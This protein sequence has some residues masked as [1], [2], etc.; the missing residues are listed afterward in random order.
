METDQDCCITLV[1]QNRSP[2][3]V[4]LSPQ[5]LLGE[6]QVAN[7]WAE[8]TEVLLGE[9]SSE[10]SSSDKL[11]SEEAEDERLDTLW[12]TLNLYE[13]RLSACE[14]MQLKQLIG[15]YADVFALDESE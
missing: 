4:H 1:V 15:D 7:I 6:L 11:K 9:G 3:A 5:Q 14:V 8:G 2:C 10:H 13:S 12:R